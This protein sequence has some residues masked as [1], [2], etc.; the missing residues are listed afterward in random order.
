MKLNPFSKKSG[1]LAR[2]KAEHAEA[3]QKLDALKAHAA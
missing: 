2:I 3:Q 1:Y